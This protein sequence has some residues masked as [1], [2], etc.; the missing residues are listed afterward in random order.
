MELALTEEQQNSEGVNSLCIH[1]GR[2]FPGCYCREIK[3][4]VTSKIARFCMGDYRRCPIYCMADTDIV[5]RK[6]NINV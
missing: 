5:N 1:A 3:G 4:G 6:N 2:P